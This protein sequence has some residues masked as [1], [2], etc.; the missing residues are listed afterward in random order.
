MNIEEFREQCLSIKGSTE[1]LP[2][3]RHNILGFKVMDKV[4]AYIPLE[5]KDGIFK[6]NMKC[7]PERSAEL[8]EQYNGVTE[9]SYKT[10]LWNQIS[11][12]SDITDELIKELVQHSADEV[13]KNL[14][15]KKQAE[16]LATVKM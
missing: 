3:D 1:S 10:I 5:P 15:K 6:V 9:T 13:I 11:L 2:W 8:R 7:D 4:F 14:P 16:Y 12:E